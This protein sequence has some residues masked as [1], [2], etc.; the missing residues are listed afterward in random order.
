MI[1]FI[2]AGFLEIA[3]GYF[4]WLWL[5][6][7]KSFWFAIIGAILLVGYGVVPTFQPASFGRVYA[8]FARKME[9]KV[10]KEQK[11]KKLS[12]NEIVFKRNY[13][14]LIK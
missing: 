6:E 8:A 14:R 4:I 11:R 7:N 5:R 10:V 13:S 12:S 9:K 3:G 2:L 1:Y